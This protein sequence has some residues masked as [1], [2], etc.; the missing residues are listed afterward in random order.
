MIR[1]ALRFAVLCALVSNAGRA[2]AEDVRMVVTPRC[3]SV[4]D[5]KLEVTLT[6]EAQRTLELYESLLPWRESGMLLVAHDTRGSGWPLD[7]FRPISDPDFE[8][9]SL[10]PGDSV[11]G[12]IDLIARFKDLAKSL[13]AADVAIFWLYCPR[14][15]NVNA[16]HKPMIGG[17]LLQQLAK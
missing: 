12:T 15:A 5:C 14:G 8:V 11:S 16:A 17:V 2:A 6:N 7:R 10:L 3:V 1:N 13:A 4:H 9:I